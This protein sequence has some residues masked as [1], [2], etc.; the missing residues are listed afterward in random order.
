MDC[1]SQIADRRSQIADRGLW[2]VDR[3][4]GFCIFY[5][6]P[7]GRCGL[8]APTCRHRRSCGQDA[9]VPFWW[10]GAV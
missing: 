8:A 6:P 10:I 5:P 3:R 1:R 9:Q 2:I 7:V 4:G